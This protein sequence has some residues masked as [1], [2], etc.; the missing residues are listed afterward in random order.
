MAYQLDADYE[1]VEAPREYDCGILESRSYEAGW[2]KWQAL[3]DG[4][5]KHKQ[6][7]RRIEGGE[8]FYDVRGR[9][10]PFIDDLIRQYQDAEA[11]LLCVGHGGLYWMMLPLVLRNV[12]HELISR[13]QGFDYQTIMVAEWRPEGLVCVEWNGVGRTQTTEAK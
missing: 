8:S 1:V 7:E 13:Q 5:V 10:V 4:W 3:W 11:N 12:D 6:W 9:F 2:Q